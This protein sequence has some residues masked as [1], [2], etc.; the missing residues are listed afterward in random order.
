MRD[1]RRFWLW[2]AGLVLILTVSLLYIIARAEVLLPQGSALPGPESWK[3]AR[4]IVAGMVEAPWGVVR[5][6]N[7]PPG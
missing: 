3:A 6:A 7:L 5:T 1:D 2:M 4:V